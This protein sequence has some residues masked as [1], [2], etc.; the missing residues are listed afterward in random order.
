MHGRRARVVLERRAEAGE[1]PIEH[2]RMVQIAGHLAEAESLRVEQP[3][4]VEAR[5]PLAGLLQMRHIGQL[6]D[7]VETA[8]RIPAH[9]VHCRRQY[10]QPQDHGD[11]DRMAEIGRGFAAHLDGVRAVRA[12]CPVASGRWRRQCGGKALT[13]R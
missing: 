12:R 4:L 3:Q 2:R 13:V 5:P 1:Q 10:E 11:H 7:L 9:G 8:S 6:R